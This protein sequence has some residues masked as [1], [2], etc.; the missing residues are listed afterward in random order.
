[1][2][3]FPARVPHAVPGTASRHEVQLLDLRIDTRHRSELARTVGESQWPMFVRSSAHELAR[4]AEALSAGA[5]LD[6]TAQKAA[7]HRAAWSMV[8]LLAS[9]SASTAAANI[10]RRVAIAERYMLQHLTEPISV[11]DIAAS[12]ELSI[13]QL[14]RLYRGIGRPAPAQRLRA[15]RI[16]RARELLATSLFTVKEIAFACGFVCPN[17]FCRLFKQDVGVTPGDYRRREGANLAA[18]TAGDSSSQ[19][20]RTSARRSPALHR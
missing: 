19:G 14:N 4:I 11:E 2:A 3:V 8:T 9:A 15:M 18:L 10:D 1:M 13:S 16:D 17:H 5:T 12:C 6:G 20:S 7:I